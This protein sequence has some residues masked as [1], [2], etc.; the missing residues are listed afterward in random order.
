[1]LGLV[2]PYE[3]KRLAWGRLQ[4]DLF[5]VKRDEKPQLSH[6]SEQVEKENHGGPC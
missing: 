6:H 4:N 5:C 1:V 2:F 3:A